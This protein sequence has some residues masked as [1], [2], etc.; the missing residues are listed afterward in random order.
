MGGVYRNDRRALWIGFG[1][2]ALTSCL[3]IQIAR[4]VAQPLRELTREAQAIGR[5]DF[6]T[7]T[8]TRSR[9]EEVAQQNAELD[10]PRGKSSLHLKEHP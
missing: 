7:G 8:Q 5:L 2:L 6:N 3:A 10:F 1:C 9:L 4:R